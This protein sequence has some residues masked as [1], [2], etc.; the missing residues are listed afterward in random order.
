MYNI[1]TTGTNYLAKHIH[2][3]GNDPTQDPE[4]GITHRTLF[5]SRCFTR[6]KAQWGL[7]NGLP[8]CRPARLLNR[9]PTL[10]LWH[11]VHTKCLRPQ[12][13]ITHPTDYVLWIRP[14]SYIHR[15]QHHW[16]AQTKCLNQSCINNPKHR[17]YYPTQHNTEC[18]PRFPVRPIHTYREGKQK[19]TH[20]TQI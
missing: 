3:N 20:W 6:C 15:P 16:I 9:H 5:S 18:V 8:Y 12:V 10:Q 19:P 11:S 13:R 2:I 1:C 7:T 17:T 4:A 14:E